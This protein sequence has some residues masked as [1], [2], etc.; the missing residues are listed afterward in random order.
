MA[1]S[2]SRSV[3]C[4]GHGRWICKF[5]I[6]VTVPAVRFAPYTDRSRLQ[7]SRRERIRN[8]NV[9]IWGSTHELRQSRGHANAAN[10]PSLV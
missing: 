1:P 7:D 6:N 2:D 9:G 3:N 10:D 8:R 5:P 4:Y